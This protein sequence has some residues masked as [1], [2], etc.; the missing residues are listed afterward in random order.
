M[1]TLKREGQRASEEEGRWL[2]VNTSALA[3]VGEERW[4]GESDDN[5]PWS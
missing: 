4:V 2:H 1:R 5:I 3:I